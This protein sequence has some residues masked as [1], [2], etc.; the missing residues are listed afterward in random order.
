MIHASLHAL[1]VD[2][3]QGTDLDNARSHI[4]E[5]CK[6]RSSSLVLNFEAA[7]FRPVSTRGLETCERLHTPT[8]LMRS[9]G[10]GKSLWG[11]GAHHGM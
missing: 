9:I 6:V 3:S 4:L 10:A 11:L 2:L 5:Y 1:D 7:S 8:W